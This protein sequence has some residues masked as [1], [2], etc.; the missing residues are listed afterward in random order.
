MDSKDG[1]AGAQPPMK[2]ALRDAA[3][4]ENEILATRDN[5]DKAEIVEIVDRSPGL[6]VG[7]LE[8]GRTG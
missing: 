7:M 2:Q 3:K 6:E 8:D 5:G 1:C 4:A